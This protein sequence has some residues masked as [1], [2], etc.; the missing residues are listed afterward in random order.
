MM[1]AAAPANQLLASALRY[2]ARGWSVFPCTWLLDSKGQK[3]SCRRIDCKSPGK[4]PLTDNGLK[5][6]TTEAD[7][8]R[9]WWDTWPQAH[10]AIRTGE[11]L[12]IIDVDKKHDG[13]EQWSMLERTYGKFPDGPVAYTVNGGL[14]LYALTDG[15]LKSTASVLAAG[16]DT[17]GT[18]GYVIAPPSQGYRWEGNYDE[19]TPLP[20]MP[21]WVYRQAN[22]VASLSKIQASPAPDG[23][24]AGSRNNALTQAAGT[25]RR[26]GFTGDE[27]LPSL[28]A[29]NDRRCRPP[30]DP[31][32]V[33]QIAYS[34]ERYEP[35]DPITAVDTP[36]LGTGNYLTLSD[37]AKPLPP[38]PWVCERLGI[39]AGRPQ[40]IAGYG[41]SGKTLAMQTT[42]LSIVAGQNVFGVF[43]CSAGRVV[44][45]DY[46]QGRYLT[47]QRY[48]RLA[49]AMSFDFSGLDDDDL[50]VPIMPP[51]YLDGDGAYDFFAKSMEGRTWAILDSLRAAAP[52]ADENSSEVR[53]HIDPLT[54][55]SEATGCA[56][57]VI[58]HARKPSEDGS[59]GR[60]AIRG[61]GAIYDACSSV[62]VFDG[63]KGK[64]VKVTCE[65]DALRGSTD[66]P[67]GLRFEDVSDPA[68]DPT[69]AL[70]PDQMRW[71]VRVVHLEPEQLTRNAGRIVEAKAKVIHV[72]RTHP[73]C[74]MRLLRAETGMI[75][76]L[77]DEAVEQLMNEGSLA[78]VKG[79]PGKADSYRAT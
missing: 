9:K 72:V 34:V 57:S 79:G 54:R 58:H 40:L 38:I 51:V 20:P 31:A 41:F 1:T 55:A 50:Y 76:A 63:D 47:L 7:Q 45:F 65:K 24:I 16:V 11:G 73:G 2:A 26:K 74:S 62:Y 64:P 48:Q 68:V 49:R 10:V 60:F 43:P 67:F 70:T 25:M 46:E 19:Q 3:C 5:D 71:G 42:A 75:A 36:A 12:G 39:A 6:A 22:G 8:I 4:H 61:S 35:S 59:G 77:A 14:H 30:L 21:A 37:L 32:E 56:I 18:G 13:D 15:H 28:L 17:R 69:G 53:R 23:Y 66:N 33:K 29:I 44:H 52:T 27:I 78:C